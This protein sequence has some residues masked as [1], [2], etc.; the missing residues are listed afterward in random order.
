MATV[1]A[2]P[3]LCHP[4][5]RAYVGVKCR[6]CWQT[7]KRAEEDAERV[8]PDYIP[9]LVQ[10]VVDRLPERCPQ[11]QTGPPAWRTTS[12]YASCFV[13][14]RDVFISSGRYVSLRPN[15]NKVVPGGREAD[16]D[17]EE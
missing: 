6:A 17:E 1:P 9:G 7:S 15:A 12:N 14:G 2:K 11:C 8:G 5:R 4:G 16:T 3:S 10:R 13:C